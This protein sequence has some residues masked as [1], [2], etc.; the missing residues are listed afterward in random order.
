MEPIVGK[1]SRR[2]YSFDL[3][4]WPQW[5]KKQQEE[6]SLISE[7]DL[8]T[9]QVQREFHDVITAVKMFSYNKTGTE[10]NFLAVTENS[11]F[12]NVLNSTH[13]KGAFLILSSETR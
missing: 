6:A 8:K 13:N 9:D 3:S 12:P 10:L 1:A 4:I 11:E 7:P 2:H 5:E